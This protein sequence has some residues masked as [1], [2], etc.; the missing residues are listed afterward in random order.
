MSKVKY[1]RH[2]EY[3]EFYISIDE[4]E[5]RIIVNLFDRSGELVYAHAFAK[6]KNA[7]EDYSPHEVHDHEN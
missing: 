1:F 4:Q 5:K 6:R 3:E 7:L 2:P